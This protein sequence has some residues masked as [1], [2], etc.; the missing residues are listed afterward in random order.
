MSNPTRRGPWSPE[1]DQKLMELISV[2]GPTNWVRISNSLATR[3]PKQC[4]ERYH[5]NLKPSL[6]R[7]PISAEE[8]E[9][10]E[11]LVAK[12]GKKWAEIARHLNG[13]SD[14][15]I[16]NWWNGGASK[17]RRASMQHEKSD[18]MDIQYS[19][20]QGGG[21]KDI[22]ATG[23]ASRS[24][25]PPPAP[26][27]A[28]HPVIP[29]VVPQ[30]S[31]SG[32][33]PQQPQQLPPPAQFQLPP[34]MN[35]NGPGGHINDTTMAGPSQSNEK[36]SFNTSMFN[37]HH[38]NNSSDSLSPNK[39]ADKSGGFPVM[40][41]A[42]FD[43]TTNQ[44]NN[45]NQL[46]PL[47]NKRRLFDDS[48]PSRRHST[49]GSVNSIYSVPA[50]NN[51]HLNLHSANSH[52]N[53]T[54]LSNGAQSPYNQSPLLLSNVNSRNNS[55]STTFDINLINS[56]NNSSVNS[57]RSS[58]APD[59]FPNPL[60]EIPQQKRN[61]SVGSIKSQSSNV[62]TIPPPL[63]LN[64]PFIFHP[65]NPSPTQQS[66][67]LNK[68]NSNLSTVLSSSNLN[69]NSPKLKDKKRVDKVNDTKI[70]VSSLID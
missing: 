30:S 12:Y 1:E 29:Q 65:I 70:S 18:Q 9:L 5:Q 42:S 34:P 63:S 52:T 14:N 47:I 20:D 26:Y 66:F 25:L 6:N 19:H 32:H 57:R 28:Q 21:P 7:T 4:R 64:Q 62:N 49:A 35:F 8:G 3:L 68:S 59:F 17:R 13:R 33:I 23:L 41:S 45:L 58:I 44:Q 39:T 53:L 60:K 38:P 61:I 46:P 54:S 22:E 43:Y 10:I 40:R 69:P 67:N 15:A 24:M 16:K 31:T 11:Q 48:L 37:N 56:N 51:S 2:F 55:I 27:I 50:G 36:I